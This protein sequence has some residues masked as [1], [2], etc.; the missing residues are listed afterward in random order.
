MFSKYL[1]TNSYLD[2]S[3]KYFYVSLMVYKF[4]IGNRLNCTNTK[5][6]KMHEV[7]KLHKGTKLHKDNF[8]Q[9]TFLHKSKKKVEKLNKN[10]R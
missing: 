2:F 6:Q 10:K 5:M 3:F 7:T 1:L 4:F 9:V 8:A